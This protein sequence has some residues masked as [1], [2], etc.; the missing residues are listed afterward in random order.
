MR[1]WH[2]RV[3]SEVVELLELLHERAA[4]AANNGA[5]VAAA[6]ASDSVGLP[7]L[8]ANVRVKSPGRAH[9]AR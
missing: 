6:R 5:G 7:D 2:L 4:V 8:A 9:A 1:L 3:I